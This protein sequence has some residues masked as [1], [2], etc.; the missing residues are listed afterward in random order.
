MAAESIE[1]RIQLYWEEKKVYEWDQNETRENSFIIDTP[2]PTVSGHLHVGHIFSYSHIDFIA[3]FQRMYGKNVFYPIGFDDNGLPTERLVEKQRNIKAKNLPREEFIKICQEVIE[4]EEDKFRN[5]FKKMAYSFDW[6]LQYQ[7]ISKQTSQISQLS[8]LDLVKKGEVYRKYQPVL[9]DPVDQTALAQAEIE[10]KEK[11]SFMNELLFPLE[12]G[13]GIHIATTRPEL[14]AACVAVLVN[15]E[16]DRYKHLVGKYATTPLFT[17]KVK[18]I[19][20]KNVLI[21]KGTGAVMCCTFGDA[22]DILWWQKYNLDTKMII[23]QFGKLAP[24]KFDHENSAH[25]D[26]A[27]LCYEKLEG[28]KI[29][30]ARSKIIEML[31]ELGFLIKQN[32]ITQTVKCAERSGA[33][34]EILITAQWFVKTIEHKEKLL[35]LSAQLNWHPKFMQNRLDN[36]ING[37]SWDW[38]ISRQRF[39]GVPFPVWYSKRKGEEGKVILADHAK[40]PIDPM[41]DLPEGYLRDE[42][43][44]DSDVM[45]T[46]ATSCISPQINSKAINGNFA[47]DLDRHKKTFPADL[48]PQA[49]EII[50]IWAFGTI[51]KSYLHEQVLPW[52]NIMIS[53][54]CLAEDK[55]KMSKSKGNII[56]PLSMLEK[57]GVDAIRYWASTSKS[58]NDTVF[59]EEVVLNGKKLV[60]KIKNAAKFCDLHFQNLYLKRPNLSTSS[61]E[62]AIDS[63]EIFCANDMWLVAK[64]NH[65][66]ITAT[67]H[68]QNFEYSHARDVIETFF[69]K[70]F[71]DTYLEI[72]KTRIYNDNGDNEAGQISAMLT[73][74]YCLHIILKLFA[75]F[76]AY[77]SEEVYIDILKMQHSIHQKSNWPKCINLVFDEYINH[78]KIIF[79][80]LELV[81]KVKT[82][83]QLS[84]KA[85]IKLLQV[86]GIADNSLPEDA[87]QDLLNVTCANKIELTNNLIGDDLIEGNILKIKVVF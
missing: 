84:I 42:V 9:W 35:E 3:R 49:H 59:S 23:D 82:Q 70:D 16:D 63:K 20:D 77:R 64:L 13:G 56:E 32:E 73:L 4:V 69:W 38:C 37:V 45:D 11:N 47:V 6:S 71:C 80:I 30:A 51:L 53:G 46:W 61:F 41:V 75:P 55:S 22:T 60:N 72:V 1:K 39:F 19:A 44:A 8:F 79:D 29:T 66:V 57:Y 18:I 36:W 28:L 27:K 85:P 21:D 7:T 76:I 65:V 68:F 15:P 25:P 31:Q 43:E 5:L 14:L 2:P 26:M 52:K 86:S 33:P 83:K 78:E 81:R 10:D 50:R 87:T 58:G 48:R 62:Q 24:F 67:N 74:Y 54:W 17:G 12:E 40:L 34:L